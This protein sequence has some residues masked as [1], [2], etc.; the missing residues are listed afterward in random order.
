MFK[1]FLGAHILFVSVDLRGNIGK[2]NEEFLSFFRPFLRGSYPFL[3][4]CLRG[5][6]PF[7]RPCSGVPILF[8]A[9][10]KGKMLGEDRDRLG[11]EAFCKAL[12]FKGFLSFFRESYPFL[13]G[14]F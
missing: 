4:P 10:F 3:M 7:L 9:L 12:F 11:G 8:Q 2:H 14:L 5:S 13:K 1:A 6:Y